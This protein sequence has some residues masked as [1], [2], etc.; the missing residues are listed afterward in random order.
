MVR[1]LKVA[2][3]VT[4]VLFLIIAPAHRAI[5]QLAEMRNF[6]VVR[7]GVLYRAG[8]MSKDGLRRLFHDFRIKTV[9]NLRDGQTPT[10]REE[11]EFCKSEDV[12]FV[13]IPPSRWGDIGGSVPAESGVRTFRA[14]LRNPGNY[15]ILVHC[16]AGIHRTG[17]YCAIY[18][19]EREHW[20][21]ARAIHEMKACGYS[22]LDEELDILG[23]MEQYRPS[24]M[25]PPKLALPNGRGSE[26]SAHKT[27]RRR[28][29]KRDHRLD[30][31]MP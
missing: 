25:A 4:V 26:V 11:E 21:N 29:V 8:Q 5:K 6:R 2:V 31:A 13:R 28:R 12:H 1:A 20:T 23:Y 3:G 10:D 9:I 14:L 16:Y 15:P 18:R 17:A 27:S 30:G 19:M 24:W 7:P 22:N